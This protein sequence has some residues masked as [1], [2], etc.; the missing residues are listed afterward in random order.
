M[1]FSAKRR[2]MAPTPVAAVSRLRTPRVLIPATWIAWC[3]LIVAC[4]SGSG[5]APTPSSTPSPL[6]NCSAMSFRDRNDLRLAGLAS[7]MQLAPR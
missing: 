6:R 3:A 2:P 7:K 5:E 4:S 1:D